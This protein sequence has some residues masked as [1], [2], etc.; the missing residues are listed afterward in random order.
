ML[1]TE[2]SGA[3]DVSWADGG[4]LVRSGGGVRRAATAFSA[5]VLSC[6]LA[7]CASAMGAGHAQ[8][9]AAPATSS[10]T[11]SGGKA[12]AAGLQRVID[13]SPPGA[14][15]SIQGGTCLISK[16]VSLLSGRTYTGGSTTRTVLKQSA[17]LR[18]VLVSASYLR[19]SRTT[20]N[21]LA[22]RDLTVACNG[23]GATDGIVL[24]NW[25]VDV[26][27]V[28]VSNCGGSGIVDT[29]AT[30]DGRSI[31]NTSVNS[32]FEDN[33]ITHSGCHGFEVADTKTAV[34]D[35]YLVNNQIGFSGMDAIRLQTAS[36]WV[37]S[38]NHLY[39]NAQDAINAD[40]LYGTTIA[41]NYIEDFGARQHSGTWYG[42]AGTVQGKVGST[43]SGNKLANVLGE[44]PGAGHVYVAITQARGGTGYLSVTGNVIVGARAGD[45]GFSYNGSP[46]KLLV[47]SAGNAVAGVSTMHRQSGTVTLTGGA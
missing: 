32:R 23:T 3:G 38:G 43:I 19:N 37:V 28:N 11:C 22:I 8:T 4:N 29:S 46:D 27:H 7:S 39:G 36:G 30:A 13:S 2:Q 5:A 42:I 12:D 1:A 35:G 16:P 18:Y 17:A 9:A 6:A 15:V 25:Q 20:G 21:P 47:A 34:T 10:F 33:F 40:G 45:V 26:E 24:L 14:A 31:T 41:N 44:Q